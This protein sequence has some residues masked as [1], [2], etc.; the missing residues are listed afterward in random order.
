MSKYSYSFAPDNSYFIF[1]VSTGRTIQSGIP[2]LKQVKSVVA[3]MLEKQGGK[4]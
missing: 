4:K 3:I 1:E 2:D